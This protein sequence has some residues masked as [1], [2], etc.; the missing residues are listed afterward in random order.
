VKKGEEG[1]VAG[2]ISE[3]WAADELHK[4]SKSAQLLSAVVFCC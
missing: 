1:R 4:K 2:K 3:F